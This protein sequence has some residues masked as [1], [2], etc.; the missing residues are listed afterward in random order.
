MDSKRLS[1]DGLHGPLDIDVE[2]LDENDF[3][4]K[5]HGRLFRNSVVECIDVRSRSSYRR[6][7]MEVGKH[8]ASL[9]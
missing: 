5:T 4:R 7:T 9:E 8:K 2:S 6:S 1:S 3:E